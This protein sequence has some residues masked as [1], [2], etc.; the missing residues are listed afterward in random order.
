LLRHDTRLPFGKINV[1]KDLPELQR[2]KVVLNGVRRDLI[3]EQSRS[4]LAGKIA[5]LRNLIAIAA[6]FVLPACSLIAPYDRAAYEHATNAKVD[7]LALMSKATRSYDE[8]EKDVEALVRQLDK[9]YEYDRGRQL[10]QITI[11]QWDILRDPNRDLVGGFLKMWKA[12][13][14][15]SATFI[16][17]K[18]RQVGDA[19]DQIIQLESG[20][21]RK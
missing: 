17:E 19:F 6:C 10:N 9:A 7:T 14:T 11:A 4:Q 18:K 3:A 16:A 2:A 8:H 15:L 20:K 5:P 1:S 13:G 21:L 12:K